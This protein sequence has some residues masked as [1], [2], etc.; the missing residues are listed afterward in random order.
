ME[1]LRTKDLMSRYGLSKK[2]VISY[3]QRGIIPAGF[4][5]G[6]SWRWNSDELDRFDETLTGNK[7]ITKEEN[8]NV[9]KNF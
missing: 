6:G 4:R 5:F 7:K 2:T 9:E 8:N 3:S 1:L